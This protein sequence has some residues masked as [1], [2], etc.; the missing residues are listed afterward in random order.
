[1]TGIKSLDGIRYSIIF[2]KDKAK[3]PA[4]KWAIVFAGVIPWPFWAFRITVSAYKWYRYT[5][6]IIASAQCAVTNLR[7]IGTDFNFI[8]RRTITKSVFWNCLRSCHVN[9]FQGIRN[10][11]IV[12]GILLN[13]II[14]RRV[15]HS[16][17]ITETTLLISC[18]FAF[19][20][21]RN[22]HGFHSG[23]P[24][25]RKFF[26]AVHAVRNLDFRRFP[27]AIERIVA[28]RHYSV[29]NFNGRD[30]ILMREPRR[31]R[32]NRIG[33]HCANAGNGELA[34]GN[35]PTQTVFTFSR[36]CNRRYC[37]P[38]DN[39]RRR[40]KLR[41][42]FGRRTLRAFLVRYVLMQW[43]IL[44]GHIISGHNVRIDFQVESVDG[45]YRRH[46]HCC[47]NNTDYPIAFSAHLAYL[48]LLIRHWSVY[49]FTKKS[50]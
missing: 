47:E 20:D 34:V 49:L 44:N 7:H 19:S 21:K 26:N 32:R 40:R 29:A 18:R 27:K 25:K 23:A 42:F 46:H 31:G 9:F 10:V 50:N 45:K 1:M 36:R 12:T 30:G 41:N 35:V 15:R 33:V 17:Q 16:E 14:L 22:C 11:V 43:H 3:M 6:K 4:A 37:L 38:S 2:T 28:N 24:V 13:C 5:L 8:Q 39:K 48:L